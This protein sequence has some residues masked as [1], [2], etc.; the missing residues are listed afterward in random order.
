MPFD[1]L[2]WL[3]YG[4]AST[5]DGTGPVHDITVEDDVITLEDAEGDEEDE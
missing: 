1:G 2:G 3:T 5:P 4:L